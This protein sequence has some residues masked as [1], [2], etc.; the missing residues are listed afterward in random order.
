MWGPRCP[1]IHFCS[2]YMSGDPIHEDI[3][4]YLT[5]PEHETSQGML[6]TLRGYIDEKLIAWDRMVGF[7]TDGAPS[8]V[9]RRPGLCTL[10]MNVSPS[11]IWTHCM[12]HQEKLVAKELS[13]ELRYTAAGNFDCKLY[14]PTSTARKPVRKTMWRYGIRAWQCFISHEAWWLSRET[15]GKIFRIERGT[16]VIHNGYKKQT[17]LTFCVMKRKCV[18]LPVEQVGLM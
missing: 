17:W 8:M 6:S 9:E 2:L 14:Q 7:C 4:F 16:V 18:S 5:T 3:W 12:I 10:V 1:C 15:V 11:A 13:T